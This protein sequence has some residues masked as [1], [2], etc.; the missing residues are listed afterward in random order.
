MA[1]GWL[2]RSVPKF[3]LVFFCLFFLMCVGGRRGVV[4]VEGLLLSFM[5]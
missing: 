2:V 1:S 5:L 3:L 4:V